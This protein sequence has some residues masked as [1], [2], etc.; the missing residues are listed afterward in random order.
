MKEKKHID[1][2]YQEK[3]RDFEATPNEA[4]WRSISAKLQ[5]Q[6]RRKPIV[7]PLW[8]RIAGVAAVLSILLMISQWI[9]PFQSTPIVASEEVEE[10]TGNENGFRFPLAN[11]FFDFGEGADEQDEKATVETTREKITA[12]KTEE[13]VVSLNTPSAKQAI[14]VKDN[15]VATTET[16]EKPEKEKSLL[17]KDP[18]IIEELLKEAEE[19]VVSSLPKNTFEIS[20]HAAPIYYGN[21]GKGN[22]IDPRF[23]NYSSE[24]EVSYSYGINIAY[25]ISDKIKIRSGV[26]KVNMSYNTRGIQYNAVVGPM[27]ISA[28]TLNEKGGEM[29]VTQPVAIGTPAQPAPSTNKTAAESLNGGLLNQKMGF[30]EVPVEMMYNVIDKRFELNIIGGA[31]TLFLDENK[32]SLDS[33]EL[34]AT[35]KANNLND[36]SFSTNIGLGLDYNLSEKF[37]L[38]LEPMLKYQINTFN[39]ASSDSQPYYF[40][41]YSGFSFKF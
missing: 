33:G 18:S 10:N 37:K 26:N 14:S 29:M 7:L 22:F 9:L 24:G 12:G 16:G 27:A 6:E 34:S 32:V 19:E 30:I 36:I 15:E 25:S 20:T 38:N 35:G 3:F 4:V 39:S 1:R 11:N 8:S 23:N 21:F 2:L 28:V 17:I 13:Q 31:S 40:G 41:I 5:E